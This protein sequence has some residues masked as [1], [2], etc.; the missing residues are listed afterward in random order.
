ML[1]VP[2]AACSCS[3]SA[4]V[5]S[6]PR[7]RN[8]LSQRG[9][10]WEAVAYGMSAAPGVWLALCLCGNACCTAVP[11]QFV[12]LLAFPAQAAYLCSWCTAGSQHKQHP[13][14]LGKEGLMVLGLLWLQRISSCVLQTLGR[15]MVICQTL[16]ERECLTHWLALQFDVHFSHQIVTIA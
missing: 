8:S 14:I 16:G 5:S 4:L 15:L 13:H 10:R 3:V 2:A 11:V 7:S 1:M 12:C 6:S 9:Q